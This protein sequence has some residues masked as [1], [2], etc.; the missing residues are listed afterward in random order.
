MIA[1]DTLD[2]FAAAVAKW[3]GVAEIPFRVTLNKVWKGGMYDFAAVEEL[4]TESKFLHEELKWLTCTT[5]NWTYTRWREE[6]KKEE[7]FERFVAFVIKSW[8]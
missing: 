2:Q 1:S 6:L 4:L 7:N 8:K 5:V 3:S